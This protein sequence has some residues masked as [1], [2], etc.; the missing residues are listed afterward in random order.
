MC[1]KAVKVQPQRPPTASPL[2]PCRP[3]S[4]TFWELRRFEQA[5]CALK[6][7]SR[8]VSTAELDLKAC[9]RSGLSTWEVC[10]PQAYGLPTPT[11]RESFSATLLLP[12]R[13]SRLRAFPWL[14]AKLSAVLNL[15]FFSCKSG[16]SGLHSPHLASWAS[17]T[18][19]WPKVKGPSVRRADSPMGGEGRVADHH[20]FCF[21]HPPR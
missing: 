6:A 9:W 7:A 4:D 12:C 19:V 3:S 14:A 5:R 10:G 21:H 8:A 15:G 11:Q 20:N 13:P 17:A 18:T 1:P 16:H 2:H